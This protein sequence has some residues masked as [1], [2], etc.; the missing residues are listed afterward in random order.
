MKNRIL[1]LV[2]IISAASA[3][4][5]GQERTVTNAD[6]AKYRDARVKSEEEL[7]CDYARLG[8]SSPEE[9]ERRLRESR[10]E[11][12]AI[13]EKLRNERIAQEQIE[14]Q[15]R[16]SEALSL[17][18]RR[19]AEQQIYVGGGDIYGTGYYVG[20]GRRRGYFG[21]RNRTQSGYFAG[22]QF[23]STGPRTPVRPMIRIGSTGRGRH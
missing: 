9:Y 8:F 4:T 3:A 17:S 10:D 2:F 22:G 20:N 18:L 15:R 6:L 23:W 19:S 12:A 14:A 13:S 5:F 11:T 16:A 1:L 21:S 7:R